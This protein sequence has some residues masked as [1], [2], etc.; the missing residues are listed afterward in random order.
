MRSRGLCAIPNLWGCRHDRCGPSGPS[1]DSLMTTRGRRTVASPAMP[2]NC[3]VTSA[4]S[5]STKPGACATAGWAA[6]SL[7]LCLQGLRG[8]GVSAKSPQDLVQALGIQADGSATCWHCQAMAREAVGATHYLSRLRNRAGLEATACQG[9]VSLLVGC[10]ISPAS[11]LIM[12]SQCAC[13]LP[14]VKASLKQT[15]VDLDVGPEVILLG[16]LLHE[17]KC[18]GQAPGPAQELNHDA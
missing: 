6:R 9:G 2:G 5:A 14:V 16:D 12:Q 15:S 11:D 8:C 4:A 7:E 17:G 1:P 3:P 10:A 13:E 18:L